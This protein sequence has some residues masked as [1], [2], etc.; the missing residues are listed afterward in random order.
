MPEDI[1]HLIEYIL[2]LSIGELIALLSFRFIRKKLAPGIKSTN[3]SILKGIIERVMLTLGFLANIPTIIVF[4][5]AIKLG[6]RLKES[7]D[8]KVSN[9]Y[10]LVGNAVSAIIA[11]LEYLFFK[12]LSK[13]C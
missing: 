9:D 10:F 12:T 4:F 8:G 11:T 1:K 13:Y 5:G 3:F 2:A 7:A 6:T